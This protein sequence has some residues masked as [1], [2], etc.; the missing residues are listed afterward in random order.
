[1]KCTKKETHLDRLKVENMQSHQVSSF[2]YLGIIVNGN[3]TL[4]KRLEKELLRRIKY[5]TQIKLFLR[6]I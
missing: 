6:G 1:M 2:S 3:N 5:T 4:K